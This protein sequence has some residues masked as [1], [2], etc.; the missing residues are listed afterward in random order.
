MIVTKLNYLGRTWMKVFRNSKYLASFLLISLIFYSINILIYDGKN[1]L[2]FLKNYGF[3]FA[4]KGFSNSFLGLLK[5]LPWYSSLSVLTTS[6][7]SGL[8]LTLLFYKFEELRI[9][10]DK[11]GFFGSAG[12][13]LG[14]TATGC[15]SCGLGIL[16]LFGIG[17]SLISLPFKGLEISMLAIIL[18]LASTFQITKRISDNSCNLPTKNERRLK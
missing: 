3:L 2:T 9:G 18:L 13:F 12:V 15:A 8:F 4:A 14:L 1:I 5:V 17:S 6:F 16:S 7:L 11:K 10:N